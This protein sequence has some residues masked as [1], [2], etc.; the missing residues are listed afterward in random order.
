MLILSISGFQGD[1]VSVRQRA[2]MGRVPL[3]WQPVDL[4]G[5][6]R[7]TAGGDLFRRELIVC[8][9]KF[10]PVPASARGDRER[11]W[12]ERF[13]AKSRVDAGANEISFVSRRPVDEPICQFAPMPLELL[14]GARIG[15]A[16]Y[17]RDV[18]RFEWLRRV[19]G[20]RERYWQAIS[21]K[22]AGGIHPI[23]RVEG[24]AVVTGCEVASG[25]FR[26]DSQA[27]RLPKRGADCG[28]CVG[29]T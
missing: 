28:F 20:Q 10:D 18:A 11:T 21:V 12:H 1:D 7:M 27:F 16:V 3:C 4:V 19:N 25:G 5:R 26:G 15:F 23:P 13:A 14:P 2:V 24:M 29:T 6:P 9:N 22:R 8:G 17:G